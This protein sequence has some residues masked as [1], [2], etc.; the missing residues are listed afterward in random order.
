MTCPNCNLYNKDG[1]DRCCSCGAMLPGSRQIMRGPY[2]WLVLMLGA[3]VLGRGA[4]GRWFHQ[5]IGVAGDRAA[6]KAAA[7]EVAHTVVAEQGAVRSIAGMVT[8]V[9]DGDTVWVTDA[10]GKH[11][12]RLNRIDAPESDQP[13]GKESAAHLKSLIGGKTVR[14]EYSSTDQY[15]R[16]LGIIFLGDTDINLQMVKDGCAWHYKH[17]DNTQSY[18]DAETAARMAKRGLWK[19]PAPIPP[20][21]FR[22]KKGLNSRRVI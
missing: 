2:I 22:K 10:S 9:S 11:K 3:M 1:E 6:A 5:V 14:V 20:H 7:A 15:G 4:L 16:I 19:D 21:E 13:F 8:R 17:F 12:V 18:A